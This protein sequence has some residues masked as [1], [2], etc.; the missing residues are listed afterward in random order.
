MTDKEKLEII[1]KCRE[2]L[3]PLEETTSAFSELG[4]LLQL[5]DTN[6]SDAARILRGDS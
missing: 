6:L 2:L 3:I 4:V 1:R 5:A